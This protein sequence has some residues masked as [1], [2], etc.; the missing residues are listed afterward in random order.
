MTSS[1]GNP[2]TA[3]E[4]ECYEIEDDTSWFNYHGPKIKIPKQEL[5]MTICTVDTIEYSLTW[6]QMFLWS[7][8]Q[9]Y[10]K[11]LSQSYLVIPNLWGPLQVVLRRKKSSQCMRPEFNKNRRIRQ[12]KVLVFNNNKVKYNIILG[13]NFL[14]KTSRSGLRLFGTWTDRQSAQYIIIAMFIHM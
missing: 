1:A 11:V 6:V 13:T 7:R 14:S 5:P 10:Q 8:D 2:S 12:Q 4:Y 9:P 3:F